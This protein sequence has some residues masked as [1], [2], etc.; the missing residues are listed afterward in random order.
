[1]LLFT[2]TFDFI[3]LAIEF[4]L[5]RVVLWMD[6]QEKKKKSSKL[7]LWFGFYKLFLTW[8]SDNPIKLYCA[9]KTDSSVFSIC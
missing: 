7:H 1:M 4:G 2:R 3:F 9:H 8:G 6:G 5:K